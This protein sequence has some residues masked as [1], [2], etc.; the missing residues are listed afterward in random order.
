M[1][2]HASILHPNPKNYKFTPQSYFEQQENTFPLQFLNLFGSPTHGPPELLWTQ[3]LI[4]ALV[5]RKLIKA[6]YFTSGALVPLLAP[7]KLC[8]E[9]QQCS[10]STAC[11]GLAGK[12]V[13]LCA[14]ILKHKA[15]EA[16]PKQCCEGGFHEHRGRNEAKAKKFCSCSDSHCLP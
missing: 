2:H 8:A 7:Q 4:P 14:P 13:L 12:T 10:S 11:K 3:A 5:F 9:A 16:P 1:K 15:M 6:N